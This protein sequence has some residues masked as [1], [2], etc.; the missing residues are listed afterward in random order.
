MT[1]PAT[2]GDSPLTLDD[3]MS[4]PVYRRL[5]TSSL[6]PGDPA[7]PFDL[8][9]LDPETHRPTGRRVRLAELAG[10]RPVALVFGSYT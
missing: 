9:L 5:M 10:E 6:A 2:P 4:S 1:G 3:I 8:P 7:L